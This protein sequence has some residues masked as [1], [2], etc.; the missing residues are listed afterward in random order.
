MAVWRDIPR[1]VSCFVAAEFVGLRLALPGPCMRRGESGQRI[2][3][4]TQDDS[5]VDMLEEGD[6]G[7][8]R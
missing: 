1:V 3:D 4:A 2:G 7:G 6:E 8:N 5:G